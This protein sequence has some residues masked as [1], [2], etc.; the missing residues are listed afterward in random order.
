MPAPFS[1]DG[2]RLV[3]ASFEPPPPTIRLILFTASDRTPP[4][5]APRR[6]TQI[7]DAAERFFFSEMKRW[8]YP[9]AVSRLFRRNSDGTVEITYVKGD[10]P[11]SDPV[12]EQGGMRCTRPGEGQEAV[13]TRGRGAH[14]VDLRLCRRPPAAVQRLERIWLCPRRRLGGRQLRH[15][16]RRDSPRPRPRG[17]FQLGVLPQGD[18][19]T[20]WATRS[21]C[22]TWARTRCS[23]WATR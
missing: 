8:K 21:G 2:R 7:A 6:L 11:A 15:D 5:D 3:Y 4:A 16:S 9:P 10:R 18:R 17:G 13:A 22:R 19:S 12:Y 14:L 20:N 23:R 1:P